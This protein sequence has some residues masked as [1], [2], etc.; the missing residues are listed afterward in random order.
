MGS[1]AELII[2]KKG[3]QHEFQTIENGHE[4]ATRGLQ[5]DGYSKPDFVA[6]DAGQLSE[7]PSESTQS[8]RA[9]GGAPSQIWGHSPEGAYGFSFAQRLHTGILASGS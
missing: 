7:D 2:T 6:A 3:L 4:A 5:E 8:S 9:Q 1:R